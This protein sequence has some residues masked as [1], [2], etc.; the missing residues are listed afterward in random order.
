MGPMTLVIGN[1]NYSSWSLRAWL[2][3][4]MAGLAF[5]EVVIPLD[6]PDTRRLI[7]EHSP[8]G[9]VPVLRHG[10]ITIWDSLAIC[11]YVAERVPG[12]RLWPETV[13]ARA[14]ARSISA[15]MHAG[16]AALRE[17]LPMNVRADR[18]GVALGSDVEA[19][20]ERILAIWRTCRRRFAANGPFL[21]G[22]FSIADAMYAPVASRFTTYR[23]PMGSIER[24]YAGTVLGLPAMREWAAAAADEPWVIAAEEVGEE[25]G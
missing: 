2:V 22:R 20:I 6:E 16:F 18:P 19:D 5:D 8:A 23:V 17:T 4:R 14:E 11:E 13:A 15:E 9:R 1:R 24:E 7:L 10:D 3:M 21:F 12:A 25:A